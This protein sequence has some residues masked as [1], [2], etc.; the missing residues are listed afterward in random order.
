MLMSDSFVKGALSG[1]YRAR[2]FGTSAVLAAAVCIGAYAATALFLATTAPA[3]SQTADDDAP[4]AKS[5][6]TMLRAG[7]TVISRNQE[8]INDPKLGD[9]GLDGKTVLAEAVK[10]YYEVAGV[11]PDSIDGNSR[12]GRLLR[13]EMDAIVEVLDVHQQTINRQGVG[14]KGFIPAVFGRLVSES[15]GRRATGLAA[16]KVTAPPKLIRNA[17]ARADEWEGSVISDK[18]ILPSWPKD[19]IFS[20]VSQTK[21]KPAYRTAMP[22]YYGA[23]C[24]NCHGSPAGEIDITGYPKEGA[25][26]GDLGGVISITLY[27]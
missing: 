5:L 23:T 18:L 20:E 3:A 10:I 7:R 2:R 4:I 11:D 8:K 15:F 1:M 12:H 26:V 24:L 9:K 14:F 21:G 25:N 13:M 27:R 22:E 17:K 19:Q 16:M 6:A